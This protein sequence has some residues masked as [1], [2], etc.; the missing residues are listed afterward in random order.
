MRKTSTQKTKLP[1]LLPILQ[2]GNM[3]VS[4][5]IEKLQHFRAKHPLRDE[6]FLAYQQRARLK[7]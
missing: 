7:D 2:K 6:R 4:V 5:A 3:A 1:K